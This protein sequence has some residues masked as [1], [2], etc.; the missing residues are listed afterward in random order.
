[1]MWLKLI[2]YFSDWGNKYIIPQNN[3]PAWKFMENYI[4]SLPY[5]SN[6]LKN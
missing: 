4:K 6:L 5:S 1:M 3:E 2:S